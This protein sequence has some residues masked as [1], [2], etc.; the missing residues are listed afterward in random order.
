MGALVVR[1]TSHVN[2]TRL[3]RVENEINEDTHHTCTCLAFAH[4]ERLD[5]ITRG[6]LRTVERCARFNDNFGVTVHSLRVEN[7]NSVLKGHRRKRVRSINCS[8]CLGLL[9][10]TITRRGNRLGRN[11]RRTRYLVSL[12]VRTR[13]PSSCVRSAPR[14]LSVCGHVTTVHA[15][16]STGSIHSRLYSHFNAP[17]RSV[18]NLVRV[19]L[20][21]GSTTDLNIC[22]V[23]REGNSILL[24]VGR[25][26]IHCTIRLGGIVG[27]EILLSTS[28]GTCVTIGL[29]A[30]SSLRAIHA[31]LRLV[32]RTGHGFSGGWTNTG[33]LLW[34]GL[35][36]YVGGGASNVV[37]LE[38]FLYHRGRV[39]GEQT[40]V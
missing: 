12:P 34:R 21:H 4:N 19:S 16:T 15:N 38:Y 31:T 37:L 22:R 7:T 14:E 17:P 35:G 23:T 3:R 24:C 10:S 40:G 2:L 27:N 5:S 30:R 36:F 39:R 29:N 1:G 32:R 20:L 25:P 6:E 8:V 11:R 28:G 26:S 13:V 18:G 9:N 33:V